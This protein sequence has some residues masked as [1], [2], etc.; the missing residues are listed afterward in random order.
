[1]DPSRQAG[2]MM[3]T[4]DLKADVKMREMQKRYLFSK[5]PPTHLSNAI[6]I[7]IC[8]RSAGLKAAQAVITASTFMDQ[9]IYQMKLGLLSTAYKSFTEAIE[10]D[11]EDVSPLVD[12]NEILEIVICLA[13]NHTL[14]YQTLLSIFLK[15][16]LQVW[17][18]RCLTR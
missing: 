14:M 5:E 12:I 6:F 4:K 7:S 1:M 10:N 11:P 16:S 3:G 13:I 9:G 8:S 15:E 17:R 18:S 2:V